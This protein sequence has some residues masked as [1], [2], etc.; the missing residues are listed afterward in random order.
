MRLMGS[1]FP[2]QGLNPGP[3]PATVKASLLDCQ[4]TPERHFQSET[5][6]LKVG[7]G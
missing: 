1:Y 5:F 3:R 7:G 4:G 2:D 6:V